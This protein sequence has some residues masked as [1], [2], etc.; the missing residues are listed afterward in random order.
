M[1]S[2]VKATDSQME[3]ITRIAFG[4]E[5][6]T[7]YVKVDFDH[8]VASYRDF[9]ASGIGGMLALLD[10]TDTVIGGLGYVI[11]PDLHYPRTLAVETFWYV[12]PSS[13]GGGILLLN[14]FEALAV[15]LNC[16]CVAMVHMV[17]SSPEQLEKL[18]ARRG[19]EIVEKHY[20]KELL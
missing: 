18:Y 13:R 6:E 2:V 19:Y 17:D 5:K 14:A 15:E 20:V 10:D 11:A 12:D 9:V 8:A 1:T 4:F 7:A 16:D 3:A